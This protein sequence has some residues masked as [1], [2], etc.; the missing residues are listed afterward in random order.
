[1]HIIHPLNPIYDKNSKVLILGTMPSVKSREANFYY[2][3]KTNRFW[4]ILGKIFNIKFDATIDK[5]EF[6]LKNNIALW[7][8]VKSCDITGS[9]DA[10]IKNVKIND[11]DKI[12]KDSNIKVIFCTGKKAYETLNKYY[13]TNIPVYYLSSPSSANA[14]KSIDELVKEYKII[15]KYL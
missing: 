14:Q 10:S 4:P 2:A 1:M 15:L 13:K 11:I 7:D 3:N 9:S 12:I 6:I 8:V 5:E